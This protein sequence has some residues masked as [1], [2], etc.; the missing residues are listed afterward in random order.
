MG[1]WKKG[2]TGKGGERAR[3]VTAEIAKFVDKVR[4]IVIS[5][6]ERN[7]SP[8]AARAASKLGQAVPE[9]DHAAEV[10]RRQA[11]LMQKQAPQLAR[12]QCSLKREVVHANL[13]APLHDECA[14]PLYRV[15]RH[16]IG[17]SLANQPEPLLRRRSVR[18]APPQSSSLSAPY[19]AQRQRPVRRLGARHA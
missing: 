6:V 13:A 18:Q 3:G 17:Q 15:R 10:F 8:I 7:S 11:G 2:W 12:A 16:R 4:L 9:A 19:F 1:D 5:G 14:D